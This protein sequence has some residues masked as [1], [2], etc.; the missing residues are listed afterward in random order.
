MA[1]NA[2]TEQELAAL[3]GALA[4]H[5]ADMLISGEPVP[6]AT[7]SAIRQFLKDNG[8]DCQGAVNPDI[9]GIVKALPDFEDEN[10]EERI[11]N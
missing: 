2:A 7:L 3:H 6:P 11:V 10:G 1:K 8:I 5:M 9:E 4:R